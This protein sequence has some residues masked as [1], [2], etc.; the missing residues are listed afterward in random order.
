MS[1]KFKVKIADLRDRC[2]HR[3]FKFKNTSEINPLNEVIGQKRAVQAIEFGLN[4]KSPGYNIFVTGVAGTGKS[5][6]V[7]DIVTQHAKTLPAPDSWCLVS[8]FKDQ[9]RPKAIAV[10]GGKAIRLSKSMTKLMD[11][12]AKD[13]PS[14]FESKPYL[15][16]LTVIKKKYSDKQNQL[17]QKIEKFAADKH[18]QIVKSDDEFETI[19]IVAG[20]PITLEDFSKLSKRK[21]TEIE[22]NIRLVQSQIEIASVEVDRLTSAL[23]TDIEKL[24]DE[25][26]LSVVKSR[27]EKIRSEFKD[28]PSILTHLD[29]V[30]QD[31]VENV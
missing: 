31:I 24:M 6:I 23:H 8:N 27:L 7:G 4:M 13:L 29:E 2:D 20:K 15:K 28:N 25:T 12:L 22:A 17:F 5:T 26:T 18:L 10:S 3:V 19:P 14:A 16:Q 11:N 21:K 1:K 9:F 30:E